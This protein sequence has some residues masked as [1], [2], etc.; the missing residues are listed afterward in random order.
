MI[1]G[2]A[3]WANGQISKGDK[4]VTINGAVVT[5]SHC[6]FNS[7]FIDFSILVLTDVS[8]VVMINLSA[9]FAL[10]TSAL[11]LPS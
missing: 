2:G 1:H 7:A 5:G 10:Q 11:F 3:A 9:F 8:I 4:I 6:Y